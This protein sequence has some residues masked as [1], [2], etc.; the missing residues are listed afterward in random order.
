LGGLSKKAFR[1]AKF[2]SEYKEHYLTI[3]GGALLFDREKL[4]PVK[5]EPGKITAAGIVEAYNLMGYNAVGVAR[6][7]LAAGLAFLKKMQEKSNF[8]WLSANLVT[9]DNHLPIFQTSLVQQLGSIKIGIIGITGEG[10][11]PLFSKTDNAVILP[12][13]QVLPELAANLSAEC[14]MIILLANVSTNQSQEIAKIAPQ[15]NLIIQA[16]T[17]I[18]NQGPRLLDNTLVTQTGKQGKYIGRLHINW[19]T[20]K[21]WQQSREEVL[22]EKTNAV[23]RTER[24][25]KRFRSRGDPEEIYKDRPQ[26]LYAYNKMLSKYER[27]EEELEEIKDKIRQEKELG[28]MECTFSNTFQALDVGMKDEPEVLAVVMQIKDDLYKFGKKEARR[29]INNKALKRTPQLKENKIT[30]NKKAKKEQGQE[31]TT[32]ERTT[33]NLEKKRVTRQNIIAPNLPTPSIDSFKFAGWRACRKC[34][35]SQVSTWISTRH[36]R[37]YSTLVAK[38]KQY[39]LDCLPCHV[40]GVSSGA[41]PF[42]RNLPSELRSVSC[43][44]CHG[45]AKKHAA[46]PLLEPKPL[47]PPEQL[48]LKCHGRAHDEAFNYEEDEMKISCSGDEKIGETKK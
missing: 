38:N 8:S 41:E 45:K 23:E 18:S 27:L 24:Q 35:P 19:H 47:A 10:R 15:V 37:A 33:Q 31:A 22:K 28:L 4:L 36:S 1:I 34:H 17:G 12:W 26:T 25:L 9:A 42:A 39:D 32:S 6:Q 46:N 2:R 3:D 16:G 40:T 7:D 44:V 29:K 11:N 21:V 14:D 5:I 43:E 30:T 13:Q 48:C 20:S